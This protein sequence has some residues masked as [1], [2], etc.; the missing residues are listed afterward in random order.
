VTAC[1]ISWPCKLRR[2]ACSK[3]EVRRSLQAVQAVQLE[4]PCCPFL[5]QPN[6]LKPLFDLLAVAEP[7]Q[8]PDFAKAANLIKHVRFVIVDGHHRYN[9]LREL[10]N[11]GIPNIPKL[12]RTAVPMKATIY[13]VI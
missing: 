13:K 5:M 2:V 1:H 8:N 4:V 6:D 10:S 7:V 3:D 11:Q 12:V 9:A